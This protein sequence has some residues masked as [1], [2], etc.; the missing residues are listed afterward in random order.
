M[1]PGRLNAANA[2]TRKQIR[3]VVAVSTKLMYSRAGFTVVGFMNQA[4]KAINSRNTANTITTLRRSDSLAAN[5]VSAAT[6]RGETS[7][8]SDAA[9]SSPR[10]NRSLPCRGPLRKTAAIQPKNTMPINTAATTEAHVAHA[11]PIHSPNGGVGFSL[12]M[13]Y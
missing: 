9:P 4:P 1:S 10:K 11:G 6:R 5:Q 7:A 3:Y 12:T 8:R 2:A 13:A